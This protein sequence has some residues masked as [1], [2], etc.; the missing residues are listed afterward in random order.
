MNQPLYVLMLF[1]VLIP[2][3]ILESSVTFNPDMRRSTD[4][5][6]DLDAI[7]VQSIETVSREEEWEGKEQWSTQGYGRY[8][9]FELCTLCG[10]V[11]DQGD[12]RDPGGREG[13]NKSMLGG[14]GKDSMTVKLGAQLKEK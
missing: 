3:N 9:R 12:S 11:T 14:S 2:A 13:T 10:S 1:V 8:S 4:F 6:L 5:S 7:L